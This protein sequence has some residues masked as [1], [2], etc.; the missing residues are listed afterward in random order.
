MYNNYWNPNQNIMYPNAHPNYQYSQNY[1]PSDET[2]YRMIHS[3]IDPSAVAN[4][5]PKYQYSQNKVQRTFN[6]DS[7]L[8]LTDHEV[9]NDIN[10][11]DGFYF[12][13]WSDTTINSKGF[14]TFTL[15]ATD[16]RVIS[17]GWKLLGRA[18]KVFA[19]ESY[20]R[21]RDQW[22]ITLYNDEDIEKRISPSLITKLP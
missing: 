7:E 21:H 4:V 12:T 3:N 22:I 9:T 8:S 20:P 1:I 6:R 15:N 19:V 10:I 11:G 18:A 2:N 14:H 13:S 5:D 17:G 16:R